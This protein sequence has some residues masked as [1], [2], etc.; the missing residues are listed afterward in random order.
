MTKMKFEDYNKIY[1]R[2]SDTIFHKIVFTAF[3]LRRDH[4]PV[5][6][7]IS[8]IEKVEYTLE[9]VGVKTYLNIISTRISDSHLQSFDRFN[10]V[11]VNIEARVGNQI[12]TL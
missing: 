8:K 6:E 4:P 10:V 2:F 12:Y 7:L 11:R 9:C 5:W 3:G 1:S